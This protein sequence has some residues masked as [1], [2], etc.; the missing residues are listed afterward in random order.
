[1]DRVGIPYARNEEELFEG[2]GSDPITD[3]DVQCLACGQWTSNSSKYCIFCAT[4]LTA[5]FMDGGKLWTRC[6]MC[7]EDLEYLTPN[8]PDCNC[9]ITDEYWEDWENKWRDVVPFNYGHHPLA[10]AVNSNPYGGARGFEDPKVQ[11]PLP[12]MDEFTSQ[13]MIC[14]GAEVG[15]CFCE[16]PIFPADLDVLGDVYP[17][18]Y[19]ENS[20]FS[21]VTCFDC[22]NQWT[23]HC[24]TLVSMVRMERNVLLTGGKF[25]WEGISIIPCS[26]YRNNFDEVLSIIKNSGE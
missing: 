24:P 11:T 21:A 26:Q 20:D 7:L 15:T 14:C 6:P 5:S 16:G 3:A 25:N 19:E 8:C 23:P 4:S 13:T 12:E 10:H 18:I 22:S 17:D 1:M 9:F 2:V